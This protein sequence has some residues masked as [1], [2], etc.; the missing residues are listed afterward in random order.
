MARP[1]AW[2]L[3]RETVVLFGRRLL[4]ERLVFFTAGNVSMRIPDEPELVAVTPSSTA[5]DTMGP[6]D[7][8]IVDLD[9][10]LV[11]G[12]RRPT[13]ELPLHT[14]VYRRRG[15]VH[16]IVHTHS[17]AAM[18]AAALGI[19]IPPILH[20]L[21]SACGGGIVS[22]PYARGGTPEVA[23]LTA[24]ALRDRSACLL[25]NHGVLAIGPTV[26][27]AY[28]AASVVEGVA[29][30]YLRARALGPVP[31]IAP[32]EVERIRREQWAPAWARV[33][34]GPTHGG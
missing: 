22:A 17:A 28:N 25:R 27:H 6:D 32:E 13:T 23:E 21:I 5:Y 8:A 20:G 11:D 34:G 9:G 2:G 7:V 26:D 24:P 29:D 30:A 19:D 12:T 15:D 3:A 1:R 10:R 16:G 33:A 18:A 4:A 14:L 31:E